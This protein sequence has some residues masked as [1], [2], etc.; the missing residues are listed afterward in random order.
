[1]L[2]S[3]FVDPELLRD[4]LKAASAAL[5]ADGAFLIVV[6]EQ[7][8]YYHLA[9]QLDLL[10]LGFYRHSFLGLGRTR[11]KES[12]PLDVHKAHAAGAV[13]ADVRMIAESRKLR[14]RLAYQFEKITLSLY[15]DIRAVY[16]H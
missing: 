15:G 11:R 6:R 14:A 10:S 13:N 2:E 8:L 12:A 4:G 5:R 16:D 1:M 9:Y 7:K 3:D